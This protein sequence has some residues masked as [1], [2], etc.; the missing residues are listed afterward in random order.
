MG[1]MDFRLANLIF[2][3]ASAAVMDRQGV[4]GSDAYSDSSGISLQSEPYGATRRTQVLSMQFIFIPHIE[5][6]QNS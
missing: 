4:A 5:A 2:D 1:C 3:S 6:D